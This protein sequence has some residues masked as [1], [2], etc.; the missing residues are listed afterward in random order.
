M[1]RKQRRSLAKKVPSTGLQQASNQIATAIEALQK[2][3]GLDGTAQMLEGL[4]A[5]IDEARS[6]ME[7]LAQ[8]VSSLGFEVEVQ[9]EVNLRLLSRL[10]ANAELPEGKALDQLKNL[11]AQVREKLL[12]DMSIVAL[13][14]ASGEG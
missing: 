12:T 5:K 3:E 2:I 9:R 10:Y 11:E 1:N 6:L 8:T 13:A 14:E 4:G 7:S